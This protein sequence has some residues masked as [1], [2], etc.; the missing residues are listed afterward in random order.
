MA[1]PAEFTPEAIASASEEAFTPYRDFLTSGEP[2][3]SLIRNNPWTRPPGAHDTLE[4]GKGWYYD[5]TVG[6][7]HPHWR[8]TILPRETKDLRQLRRDLFDWGYCLIEDGVSPEQC[9]RLHSRVEDQAAAERALGLAHANAAQ[10]HLWCLVNKGAD[11]VRCMEHDPEAVQAGP[12]I[13]ALVDETLGPGWNHYSFISNISFPGCH[14]QGLHQDQSAIAPITTEAPV[15]VN[16]V[17]ILQDVNEVNGGT[18]I[19][20]GSHK[21]ARSGDGVFAHKD[22]PSRDGLSGSA[23]LNDRDELAGIHIGISER[24]GSARIAQNSF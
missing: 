9:A 8:D 12:L 2:Y 18:L 14:P 23:L 10:Q 21:A 4:W 6:R 1:I 16:T 24:I 7:K 20:P 22:C 15:L 3:R 5:T 11:F 19:V 13:E 17:Y